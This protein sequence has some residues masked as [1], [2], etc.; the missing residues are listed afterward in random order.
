MIMQNVSSGGQLQNLTFEKALTINDSVTLTVGTEAVVDF[1]TPVHLSVMNKGAGVVHISF[2]EKPADA[3][4]FELEQGHSISGVKCNK[5]RL[6]S[7]ASTPTVQYIGG[8]L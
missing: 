3:T 5:L 7:S 6:Y 2:D 4:T 1:Q 8:E